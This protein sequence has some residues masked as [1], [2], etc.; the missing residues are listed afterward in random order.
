MYFMKKM[1]MQALARPAY[2]PNPIFNLLMNIFY[3]TGSL[4]GWER[5]YKKYTE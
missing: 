1:N 2:L 5:L 3:V 4:A